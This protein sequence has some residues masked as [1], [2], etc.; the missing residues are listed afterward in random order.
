MADYGLRYLEDLGGADARALALKE[1]SGMML[2]AWPT[3]TIMREL[4]EVADKNSGK[5]H[6][7]PAFGKMRA[8]E[9]QAG[10]D[11]P[12]STRPL[13]EERLVVVDDNQIM[14]STWEYEEDDFIS[15]FSVRQQLSTELLNAIAR[16][17]DSRAQRVA[18]LGARKPTRPTSGYDSETDMPSGNLV[19]RTGASESVVFPLTAAGS[20]KF[21]DCLSEMRTSALEKDADPA[22]YQFTCV[23]S[24]YIAQVL[25]QDDK[26][27]MRSV[28]NPVTRRVGLESDGLVRGF[29]IITSNVFPNGSGN[30]NVASGGSGVVTDGD[31]KY[32]GTFTRSSALCLMG[33]GAVGAVQFGGGIR[34]FGPEVHN[35][36]GG[37][38]LI[39]AKW[40]GGMKALRYEACG[41]IYWGTAYTQASSG[42]DF[43]P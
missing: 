23:T 29:R 18:I 15:H 37:A 2:A 7:F 25:E 43:A 38:T 39:G 27:T 3:R 12:G 6:Q 24:P 22:E 11:V 42:A 20:R 33:R 31:S 35:E 28:Y 16:L 10:A 26:I 17:W 36:K 34:S 14:A 8:R 19:N 13:S 30:D 32:Q 5:S 21:Q 4:I 9:H 41:E 40:F 1:F